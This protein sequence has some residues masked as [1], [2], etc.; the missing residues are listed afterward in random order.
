MTVELGYSEYRTHVSFMDEVASH[1]NFNNGAMGRLTSALKD[2]LDPNGVLSPGKS[3]V[4]NSK[5]DLNCN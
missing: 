4:W 2:L 5:R 3:G 1:H